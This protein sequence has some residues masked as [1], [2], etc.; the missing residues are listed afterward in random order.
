[1]EQVPSTAASNDDHQWQPQDWHAE[2]TRHAAHENREQMR[3]LPMS[4]VSTGEELANNQP[5]DILS[6]REPGTAEALFGRDGAGDAIVTNCV[7]AEEASSCSPGERGIAGIEELM[8]KSLEALNVSEIQYF[9]VCS[10][11]LYSN[12]RSI[13]NN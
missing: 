9:F 4:R 3:E 1:M 5:A 13:V 12:S 8:T 2:Q 6:G 7:R 10:F 11:F